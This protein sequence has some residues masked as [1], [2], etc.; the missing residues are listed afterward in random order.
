MNKIETILKENRVNYETSVETH[1]RVF[2]KNSCFLVTEDYHGL[3]EDDYCNFTYYSNITGEYFTDNWTTAAACP[4]YSCYETEIRYDKAKEL[5]LIDIKIFNSV[6]KSEFN[7]IGE[8]YI[9]WPE[10]FIKW[11]G[12]F[13]MVEVFRGRSF[14]N[15]KGFL[16]EHKTINK[17]TRWPVEMAIIYDTEAQEFFMVK[18]GYIRITSD[19][20]KTITEEFQKR[21]AEEM[22]VEDRMRKFDKDDKKEILDELFFNGNWGE[23]RENVY[24]MLVRFW[25]NYKYEEE[26][27]KYAPT[28]KLL[29]WVR[30]HFKDVTDEEE[31][32][33]IAFNIS[34]KNSRY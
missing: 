2:G 27:K 12:R 13:P 11:Y 3:Y 21:I 32:Y 7:S 22:K 19:F 6:W 4:P 5:G 31:I 9:K 24:N 29:Q 15:R 26:K 14:K 8:F 20:D 18:I 17:D 10:E 28:E 30:D 34:K 1:E 23:Y 25:M 33:K 16:V